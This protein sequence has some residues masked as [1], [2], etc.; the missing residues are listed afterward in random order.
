MVA[1]YGTSGAPIKARECDGAAGWGAEQATAS[2]LQD[3][4]DFSAISVGDTAYLVFTKQAPYATQFTTLTYFNP[5]TDTWSSEIAVQTST[6]ATVAPILAINSETGDLYC[7]W[8][9][10][11]KLNHVYYKKYTVATATWDTNPV[12]WMTDAL[13]AN[14]QINTTFASNGGSIGVTWLTNYAG[15]GYDIRFSIYSKH[16]RTITYQSSPIMVGATINGVIIPSGQSVQVD[17]GSVIQMT[18]PLDVITL[19]T[20]YSLDGRMVQPHP[21]EQSQ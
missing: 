3:K 13:T 10:I 15:G 17:D 16:L 14:N 5:A 8:L 11:P 1:I 2:I 12:D 4:F 21:Q 9:G 7:F 6:A 18:V 19:L 20:T